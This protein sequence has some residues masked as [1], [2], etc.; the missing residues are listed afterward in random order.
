MSFDYSD[1]AK[2]Q[3]VLQSFVTKFLSMDSQDV[4][5]Q[6]SLTVRFLED[7]ANKLQQQIADVE[8]QITT[9]KARNGA[10]LAATGAPPLIDTG[11]FSA[12]ITSLQNEN[13]QLIAASRRGGNGDNA[14]A[15]AEAQLAA[16]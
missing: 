8:N 2:A 9:L 5:D 6:A 10:A 4:E 13:R 16:A 3:A 7:Q 15:Q 14:L 1:P 12:Q 11:S